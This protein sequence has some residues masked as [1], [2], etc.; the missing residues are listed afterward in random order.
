[1][2]AII[3]GTPEAPFRTLDGTMHARRAYTIDGPAVDF[4]A[5]AARVSFYGANAAT[6]EGAKARRAIFDHL[7]PYLDEAFPTW[8][9]LDINRAELV[10][11]PGESAPTRAT[12]YCIV[13]YIERE[14]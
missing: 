3:T 9:A 13:D 7:A 8:T 1:M 6:P 12:V 2:F 4:I 14:D 10:T 11:M 5:R